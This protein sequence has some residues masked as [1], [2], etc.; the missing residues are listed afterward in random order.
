M[1]GLEVITRC[2]PTHIVFLTLNVDAVH[3]VKLRAAAAKSR[4]CPSHKLPSP[5]ASTPLADARQ[6]TA[7]RSSS[8]RNNNN[9]KQHSTV[10]KKL[11]EM[12]FSLL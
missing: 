6:L 12:F 3:K 10:P 4:S 9:K 5:G 7:G 8:T 11:P 1:A 2:L